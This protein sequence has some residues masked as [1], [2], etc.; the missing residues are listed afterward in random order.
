ESNVPNLILVGSHKPSGE[1]REFA[2]DKIET[3]P[4]PSGWKTPGQH[5]QTA[6]SQARH[7]QWKK[8]GEDETTS[9]SQSEPEQQLRPPLK[10]VPGVASVGY[11]TSARG[12]AEQR[13]GCHRDRMRGRTSSCS[14][15]E[16]EQGQARLVHDPSQ[17]FRRRPG[18][19]LQAS[20]KATRG[21]ETRALLQSDT[22]SES[23]KPDATPRAPDELADEGWAERWELGGSWGIESL[24]SSDWEESLRWRGPCGRGWGAG[25]PGARRRLPSI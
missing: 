13:R 6:A 24:S 9:S 3:D 7:A 23:R 17:R 8:D 1:A 15:K 14:D 10:L 12:S 4:T 22:G 21:G 2:T 11:L 18:K 16:H 20:S 5:H 25:V 19:L